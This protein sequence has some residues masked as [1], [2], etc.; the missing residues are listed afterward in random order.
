MDGNK[1]NCVCLIM[2]LIKS[3]SQKQSTKGHLAA[4][5]GQKKRPYAYNSS[6]NEEKKTNHAKIKLAKLRFFVAEGKEN[7]NKQNCVPRGFDLSGNTHI[8]YACAS[9]LDH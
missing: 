6:L 5:K 3:I 9:Y 2:I 8:V 1:K 7:V 4:D